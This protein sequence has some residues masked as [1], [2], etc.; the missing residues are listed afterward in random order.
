MRTC[1]LQLFLIEYPEGKEIT[2]IRLSKEQKFKKF[3]IRVLPE[4][5]GFTLEIPEKKALKL[6]RVEETCP[7]YF[8]PFDAQNLD[9]SSEHCLLYYSESHLYLKDNQS[10]NGTWFRK[11]Q[12]REWKRLKNKRIALKSRYC[13]RLGGYTFRVILP[14]ISER[15]SQPITMNPLCEEP[16]F[17]RLSE[18]KESLLSSLPKRV[19]KKAPAKSARI[20]WKFLIHEM[21]ESPEKKS[22]LSDSCQ[23]EIAWDK[24]EFGR[25]YKMQRK[26]SSKKNMILKISLPLTL[27][28]NIQESFLSEEKALLNLQHPHIAEYRELGIVEHQGEKHYYHILD[29]FSETSLQTYVTQQGFMSWEEV[30]PLAQQ[31]VDALF[32]FH[33]K[34]VVHRDLKPSNILY[35]PSNATVQIIDFALIKYAGKRSKGLPLLT[36]ENVSKNIYFLAPEQLREP[37]V[38]DKH[39]DLYALGATLYFLLTGQTP[40]SIECPSSNP[41]LF[42][43]FLTQT[44][45]ADPK[46]PFWTQKMSQNIPEGAIDLINHLLA[47]D[48]HERPLSAEVVLNYLSEELG[49]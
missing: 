1:K 28:E 7:L 20:D 45:K 9:I 19:S 11:S 49:D 14:P 34:G 29:Y 36:T 32:Y 30:Y 6:G 16:R 18:E 35:H 39:S 23:V 2:D 48:P 44:L 46:P 13:F 24:N 31:L 40:Y 3:H 25:V 26:K 33:R 37:S 4:K 22:F 12:S 10:T 47:Y 5:K 43:Q 15:L 27:Q 17:N 21:I 42:S 41:V 8:P 38:S